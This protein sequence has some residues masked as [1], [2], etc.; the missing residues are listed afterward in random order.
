[1]VNIMIVDDDPNIALLLEMTLRKNDGYNVEK[2]TDGQ[3]ALDKL[4][5][6]KPDLIL[7]DIM[8]PGID[9]FEVC[10]RIKSEEKTK[11]ISV[12][13]L[14]AK[15]DLQDKIK[16]MDIGADDYIVKPFNPDELLTR[17]QVQLRIRQL[18][19]EVVEKEKLETV[20]AMA[21]TLQHEIN[22]PLAGIL[23][24]ADLIKNWR[25]LSEEEVDESIDVILR[26]SKRIRDIV[27]KMSTA[28]KVVESTYLGDTK[29]IDITKLEPVN[30][31]S[32][33]KSA[34]KK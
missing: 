16:G 1:M 31:P 26:Q 34:E 8:M 30:R 33:K 7:L 6:F 18:E 20:L 4:P 15:R 2:F 29:M 3:T 27:Q 24:N 23:G 17:V 9:G 21:V 13:I 25:E 12:I 5:E 10:K 19:S 14:S 11:Y 28:K 22:N 32:F